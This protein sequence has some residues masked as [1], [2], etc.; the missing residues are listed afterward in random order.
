MQTQVLIIGGGA[1]GT[2]LARDL[3]LRGVHCILVE[4]QDINAGAS[5]GNHGLL[6]SGAR[7]VASDPT[8]A[9]ECKLEARLLKKLAPHCIEPTGGLFVAVAGDDETYIADFPGMCADAHIDARPLDIQTAREMEPALSD[10]LIAAYEVDDATIDPFK[11]SLDNIAHAQTLGS[12]LLRFARVNGFDISGNAIKKVRLCNRE[13]GED[14]SI[15]A[16]VVVNATGA[17][18]GE[19]AA[20]AGAAIGM[21]YSKGSLLVTQER[22]SRRVVNRLRPATNGDILVPGGTVSILGTTSE[23]V[24]SPDVI[25]PKIHEVDHIIQEGAAMMPIL[26]KIRYIR[27]Y[28]GVRPLIS[29]GDEF[30]DRSVSRGFA[31]IDHGLDPRPIKNF[32]TISG[33]KL[34]TCRLMAEKTA[35]QV[36]SLLGVTAPC[37]TRT[38]PLPNTVD[39]RWTE[40]GLAPNMWFRKNDPNDLLLCECEMVPRSVVDTIVS[41]L[42]RRGGVPDMKSIGLRSR[43]GKG[44]CQGT[45]C[46]LRVAAYLYDRE[47]LSKDQGIGALC[48]FLRERWR[49]QRPL[50]WDTALAQAELME[51]MHCGLF[52]LELEDV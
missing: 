44:P 37:R 14:F 8:S 18:A 15:E 45:F 27:A 40:P 22:V 29:S 13:T 7:Y 33:G 11:L 12:Q 39:A 16:Q 43:I 10:H 25:Y 21:V 26:G 42:R 36:C 35:D 52:G 4:K 1:T 41:T 34:T 19:V 23:R 24:E 31:L 51:A 49:G 47:A 28:C 30:D 6:H 50:M 32:I 20:L 17:W 38:E 48:A 3:A 2:G 46:S 9:C 5:G